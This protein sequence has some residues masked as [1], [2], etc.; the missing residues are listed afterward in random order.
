VVEI[1]IISVGELSPF[2]SHIK[3]FSGTFDYLIQA[4]DDAFKL[5]VYFLREVGERLARCPEYAP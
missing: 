1:G 2:H 3:L 5:G 4:L